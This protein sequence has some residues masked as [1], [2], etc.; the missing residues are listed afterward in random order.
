MRIHELYP[1]TQLEHV[2]MAKD[3]EF[4]LAHCSPTSMESALYMQLLGA[5][6][7]GYWPMLLL[8]SG[9]HPGCLNGVV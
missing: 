8:L 5:R 6:K 1:G 3:F 2:L 7:L 4:G 9:M